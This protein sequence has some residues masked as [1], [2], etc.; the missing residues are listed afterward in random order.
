MVPVWGPGCSGR[1]TGAS[2]PFFKSHCVSLTIVHAHPCSFASGGSHGKGVR[3][4][5]IFCHHMIYFTEIRFSFCLVKHGEFA[6]GEFIMSVGH[7]LF[8][9]FIEF[10]RDCFLL[11]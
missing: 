8:L 7:V 10:S 3:I 1:G 9:G 2:T 11:S 6:R 4:V 5:L